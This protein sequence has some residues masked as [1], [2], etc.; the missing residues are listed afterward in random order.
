MNPELADAIGVLREKAILSNAQAAHLRAVA[1]GEIVSVRM[2]IKALLYTGV[3]LAISGVGLFLKENH[4]RIGPTAIASILAA[5]VVACFVY[6][7]RRSPPFSWG[8]SASPHARYT[9]SPG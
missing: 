3:L 2:E 6:F 1:Q 4:D 7:L 9:G 5:A 8:A